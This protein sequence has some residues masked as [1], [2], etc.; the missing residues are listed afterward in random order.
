MNTAED[1]THTAVHGQ[2]SNAFVCTLT[3]EED[4]CSHNVLYTRHQ[5]L[6]EHKCVRYK[7]STIIRTLNGEG[8]FCRYTVRNTNH[9]YHREEQ[10]KMTS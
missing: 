1:H 6:Y 4:N 8:D 10:K 3:G 9:S 7:T 2:W 5:Q